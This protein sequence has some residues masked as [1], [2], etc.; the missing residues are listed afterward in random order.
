MPVV[1]SD[2]ADSGFMGSKVVRALRN[3]AIPEA[4][5]AAP[6]NARAPATR[7]RTGRANSKPG[8]FRDVSRALLGY[9]NGRTPEISSSFSASDAADN[10]PV[11]VLTSRP[12]ASK[13]SVVGKP[14]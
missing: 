7:M 1:T 5:N 2:E 14:R 8:L 11:R 6:T 9:G 10:S 3:A 13:N 12:S 4:L